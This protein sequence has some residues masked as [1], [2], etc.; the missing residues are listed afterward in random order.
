MNE[1]ILD[2]ES[3]TFEQV[4]ACAYGKKG[5]S[6]VSLSRISLGARANNGMRPTA[7]GGAFIR[8]T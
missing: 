4:L 2:G 3:L 6:C 1:I 7:D 8:R 5:E